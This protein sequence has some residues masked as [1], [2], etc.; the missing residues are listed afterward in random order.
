MMRRAMRPSRNFPTLSRP[1]WL[2]LAFCATVAAGLGTY[3]VAQDGQKAQMAA[4]AKGPLVPLPPQPKGVPF[5]T[6]VWP[7]GQAPEAAARVIKTQFDQAFNNSDSPMGQ[8]RAV[9]IVQGGRVVAER[10]ST[11]F[12]EKSKLVSWSMAKSVTASL[13]GIAMLDGKLKLDQPLNDPL[14]DDGDPRRDITI[15]QALHM[16]DGLRWREDGYADPVS[17]DAAK[18]LFGPGRENIVAYVTD[19]PTEFKPGEKWRYS[20][21]TTNLISAAVARAVS[22]RNLKDP[23]GAE[24][25]RNF[26][27]DRLFRPIGMNNVAAEFD[28]A[29]NFY[30]SSLMHATAQDWARY[31][32]LHLRDGVWDGKR[33]LP[34]GYVD[35]LRTPT[36]AEGATSYG[37][38]WWLSLPNKQGTLKNGPYDS[39]EAHGFQGQWIGVIPSKDLVI[40]R[41]GLMTDESG[42]DTL[43]AWLQPIVDAFPAVTQP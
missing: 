4:Y 11:G 29:G 13:V 14:W 35:F 39:F 31:G 27:Y 18:M 2:G 23:T 43:D 42:W 15:R 6:E 1:V 28:L 16:S 7:R 32:L 5:P 26:M 12:D 30:A 33:I 19:R 3:V 20:S 41:L 21:G 24:G 8:T 34:E 38:H 37:A 22:P 40:V 25:Y 10:Y 17:N 9:I 36:T